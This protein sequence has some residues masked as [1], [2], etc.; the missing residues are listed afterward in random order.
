MEKGI[1]EKAQKDAA[2]FVCVRLQAG[3]G[4]PL[5]RIA[6]SLKTNDPNLARDT[7]AI[8]DNI[9][10]LSMQYETLAGT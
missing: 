4:F 10:R 8:R 9:K 5:S 3:D 2:E 7:Q 1:L 6:S